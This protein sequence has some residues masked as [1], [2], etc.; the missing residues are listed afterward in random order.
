MSRAAGEIETIEEIIHWL[1]LD[2]KEPAF[3]LVTEGEI[4]ETIFYII[5]FNNTTYIIK[6][7]TYFFLLELSS[8]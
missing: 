3:Q 8:A 1:K 4:V 5:I 7:Y 6:I 2:E